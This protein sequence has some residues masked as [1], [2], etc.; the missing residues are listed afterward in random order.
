[1]NAEDYIDIKALSERL[2]GDFDLFKELAALYISDSP[3]L[4]S[5]IEE[6][7]KNKNGEKIGKSSHTMKGAVSN[8][9]AERAF[10]ASLAL[11]KIGKNNEFE[12]VEAAFKNL[13]REIEEMREA[14]KLMMEHRE[15]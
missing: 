10:N 11:E 3:R 13:S 4:L 14:L 12:K 9:S 15:F 7:I 2:D 8:F 5:F 6:A 1:M